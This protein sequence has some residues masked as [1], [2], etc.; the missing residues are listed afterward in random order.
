MPGV[1]LMR[2][3][4]EWM[5]CKMPLLSHRK[6]VF[7]GEVSEDWFFIMLS[8]LK[9]I[10]KNANIYVFKIVPMSVRKTIYM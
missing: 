2:A 3:L 9:I 6:Y 10:N 5:T 8:S 1:E 4:K 7:V